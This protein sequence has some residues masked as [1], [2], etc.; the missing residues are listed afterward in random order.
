M[1]NAAGH[2]GRNNGQT[3]GQ[4]SRPLAVDRAPMRIIVVMLAPRLGV[5]RATVIPALFPPVK[6]C[7]ILPGY[8]GK[9]KAAREKRPIKTS[10]RVPSGEL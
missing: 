6:G 2:T 9:V 5:R 4:L 3:S 10:V 8:R 1:N 7:R